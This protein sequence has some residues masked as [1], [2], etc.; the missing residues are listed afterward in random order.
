MKKYLLGTVALVALAVATPAVSADLG[1]RYPVK[2]PPMVSPV[3]DWTGFYVG[4]NGGYGWGRSRWDLLPGGVSEGSH[5]VDGGTVG[6]QIGYNWQIGGWVLGLEAQG[7]WADFTGSNRERRRSRP[8]PTTPTSTRSACSPARWATPGTTSWLYA[9]GGAA[10]QSVDYRYFNTATGVVGGTADETRWG[11][12]VGVGFEYAFAPN[13]SA[14]LEYNH[15]FMGKDD[16]A[17]APGAE[18]QRSHS[19]RHR[20]VHRPHQLPLRRPG[21]VALLRSQARSEFGKA[22]LRAGLFVCASARRAVSRTGSARS[23]PQ[24]QRRPCESRDPYAVPLIDSI[25]RRNG[26]SDLEQAAEVIRA[27]HLANGT[28]YGSLL[29]QGRR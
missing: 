10:V 13:W 21:P 28:A 1:A 25:A 3:F 29:S 17:F 7:N 26:L 20:R 16:V 23:H 14:G 19:P 24:I 4:I 5:N 8:P 11:G 22:G 12:T 27:F 6:G 18:C 2:A 15:L 9:K